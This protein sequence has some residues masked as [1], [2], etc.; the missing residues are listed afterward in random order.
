MGPTATTHIRRATPDDAAAIAAIHVEAWRAAYAGMLPDRY[1]LGLAEGRQTRQ[2]RHHVVARGEATLV[3]EDIR[4]L[5]GG[6][7][8][9]GFASCGPLRR[10]GVPAD[11]P[12]QG[13]VYTLY[14]AP[15]HQGHGHGGALLEACRARLARDGRAGVLVWVLAANPSRFFYERM[16][17]RRVAER[18]E[19][20]A[21]ARL[22]EIAYAWDRPAAH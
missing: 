19:P 3:A 16:G 6:P 1:L 15:D 7:G 2:W 12:W 5:R 21:G 14:V 11:A 9:V 17:G 18:T 10:A 20:F 4:P 8:I 22:P 13:E